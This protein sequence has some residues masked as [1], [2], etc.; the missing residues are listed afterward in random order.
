MTYFA[1]LPFFGMIFFFKEIP[2]LVAFLKKRNEMSGCVMKWEETD[3]IQAP[4]HNRTSRLGHRVP[5]TATFHPLTAYLLNE[6]QTSMRTYWMYSNTV[7]AVTPSEKGIPAHFRLK[8]KP[9]F[10]FEMA[11]VMAD[12]CSL[13]IVF[14]T[15]YLGWVQG[16]PCNVMMER[17][18]SCW[19]ML[20]NSIKTH[21]QKY[22]YDVTLLPTGIKRLGPAIVTIDTK[23][24][25]Q[26]EN[27]NLMLL[28]SVIIRK[29]GESA[30][31]VEWHHATLK[32][33]KSVRSL[34]WSWR[35][36]T[37]ERCQTDTIVV[38]MTSQYD[39]CRSE[40]PLWWPRR[41]TISLRQ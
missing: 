31:L 22:D 39:V 11:S 5:W 34:W 2:L 7:K 25:A 23:N 27:H 33:C 21:C 18:G 32:W 26:H 37:S 35:H 30:V 28:Y 36:D 24:I 40:R 1:V 20:S 13:S 10:V 16:W 19:P 9:S 6:F 15:I 3:Q 4:M 12:E 17:C 14:V 29:W 38:T 41:H 8:Y